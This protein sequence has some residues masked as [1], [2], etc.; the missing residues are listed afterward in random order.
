VII[1]VKKSIEF[2]KNDEYTNLKV[3]AIKNGENI[4]DFIVILLKFW[5]ENHKEK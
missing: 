2:Q 1:L 3:E 4:G 5:K